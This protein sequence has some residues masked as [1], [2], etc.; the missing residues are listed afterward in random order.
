MLDARSQRGAVAA[1]VDVDHDRPVSSGDLLG[2]VG[3]A[4]VGDDDFEVEAAARRRDV[5]ALRMQV[6]SVSASSRH[7]ITTL[8]S[9]RAGSSGGRGRRRIVGD[10]I[11]CGGSVVDHGG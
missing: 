9:G 4:V 5:D 2:A 8:R 1:F 11:R 3:A 10:A 6:S 7:G